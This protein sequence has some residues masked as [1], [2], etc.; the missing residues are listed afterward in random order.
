[1]EHI[2]SSRRV[3]R[4][5][6]MWKLMGFRQ[7]ATLSWERV[8]STTLF[9]NKIFTFRKL[10]SLNYPLELHPLVEDSLLLEK[11][12]LSTEERHR[13]PLELRRWQEELHREDLSVV[14]LLA[15]RGPTETIPYTT[16]VNNSSDHDFKTFK[17][18]ITKNIFNMMLRLSLDG[19]TIWS[20]N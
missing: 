16:Q 17:T 18:T 1:M 8:E 11:L 7:T 13:W 14:Q 12:R 19:A 3:R 5:M 15:R 9:M 10:R 4:W 2:P 6:P 20:K